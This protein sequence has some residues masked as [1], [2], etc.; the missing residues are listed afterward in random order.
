MRLVLSKSIC[1][2]EFGETSVPLLQI[3][4]LKRSC[5]AELSAQIKGEK[6]P[7]GTRL[8]KVYGTSPQGARR[9]VH[10]LAVADDTLFLLF[11]R[12]KKDQ[13]GANVTIKNNAFRRQ[14]QKHLTLLKKDLEDGAFEIWEEE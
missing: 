4:P 7:K 14:L 12:D 9:I 13:V 11:Y 1:E 3:E 6:L 5:A 2:A 8:L 10:L